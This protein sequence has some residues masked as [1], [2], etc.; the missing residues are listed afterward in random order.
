MDYFKN[1]FYVL[2]RDF[3][4]TENINF[5]LNIFFYH[6]NFQEIFS[7]FYF[8]I[9]SKNYQN[10]RQFRLIF[11]NHLGYQIINII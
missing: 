1:K 5:Y 8:P 11:Q 4:V 3:N 9:L 7:Q 6:F 2:E 10:L